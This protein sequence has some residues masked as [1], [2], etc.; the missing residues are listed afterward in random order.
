MDLFTQHIALEITP[1]IIVYTQQQLNDVFNDDR[2]IE[3]P[4]QSNGLANARNDDN[5]SIN[6][7]SN[8]NKENNSH[9]KGQQPASNNPLLQR[10]IAQQSL[11]QQ[12]YRRAAKKFSSKI[13]ADLQKQRI[14]SRKR[15]YSI[16]EHLMI[17][18]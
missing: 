3:A 12:D 4:S 18:L 10:Y 5:N 14:N 11:F 8:I 7:S 15:L 1:A 17:C 2:Q 16:V 6:N 13:R 9:L